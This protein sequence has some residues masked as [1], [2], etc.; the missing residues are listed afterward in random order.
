MIETT[1]KVYGSKPVVWPT[2]AATSPIYVIK[3]WMGIPVASG[4]GVGYPGSKIHA[5]NENIRIKDYLA[6]IKYVSA[7]ISS[8]R[9]KE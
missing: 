7:L 9:N 6:F 5:P 2:M 1:A 4:G 8:Y 3:N